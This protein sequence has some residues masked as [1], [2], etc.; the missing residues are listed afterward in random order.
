MDIAAEKII[1]RK[2]F[3]ELRGS[4]DVATHAQS[5]TVACQNAATLLTTLNITNC[6]IYHPIN[7]EISPLALPSLM[8]NVAFGLPCLHDGGMIFSEWCGEAELVQ[9][10]YGIMQPKQFSHLTPQV[11]ITPLLA[12][13]ET[14]VRLGYGGGYYDR[15]FAAHP[16]AIRIGIGFIAQ[17]THELPHEWYDLSL[18]YFISEQSTWPLLSRSFDLR[19]C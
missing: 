7:S 11:I 4:I 19:F 18:H 17:L 6:A 16:Q 3:K 8:P 2:H 14:G 12:I 1:L 10:Q 9:G 13:D 5:S 15:Y